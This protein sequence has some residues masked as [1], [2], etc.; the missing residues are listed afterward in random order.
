MTLQQ[1]HADVSFSV[2]T[3]QHLTTTTLAA[4]H[5]ENLLGQRFLAI[6][7]GAPAASPSRPAESSPSPTPRRRSI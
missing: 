7:P 3:S 4:I 6:L 2:D 5:F 1:N